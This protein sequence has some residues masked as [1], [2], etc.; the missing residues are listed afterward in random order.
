MAK[1][2]DWY[3][4]RGGWTSC[5][6]TQEVLANA[7]VKLPEPTDA[8]KEKIGPEQAVE[9]ARQATQLIAAKG[10][11]VVKYDLKKDNPSDEDLIKVMI[12]PSGNLRAPTLRTG[13]KI[14]IGFLEEELTQF[15]S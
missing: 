10:K 15:L 6:K 5:K 4:H 11:K 9:M 2:V 14:F 12:G 3:Y 1:K 8:K 13:K 7:E